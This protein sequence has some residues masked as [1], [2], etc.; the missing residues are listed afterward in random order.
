LSPIGHSSLRALDARD[1]A[2][3]WRSALRGV[4]TQIAAD[5]ATLRTMPVDREQERSLLLTEQGVVYLVRGSELCAV[6]VSDGRADWRN[7]QVLD[8]PNSSSDVALGAS[9]TDQTLVYHWSLRAPPRLTVG[10]LDRQ[11]GEK[12]WE[13]H[14]EEE[15][16][17]AIGAVKL[18]A[19]DGRLYVATSQGLF[20]FR[21]LDGQL[22][23][24]S[25][26]GT[27]LSV[28]RLALVSGASV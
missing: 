23:W 5:G 18:V 9:L 8:D 16:A 2:E 17:R 14:G 13:W 25:L 3:R 21:E 27:D 1:G 12:Q 7:A 19:G 28:V 22:L 15:L 10:A 20:A 11:T 26:L 6:R 24:R 4:S